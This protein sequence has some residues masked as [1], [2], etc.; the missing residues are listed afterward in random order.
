M[1]YL[2]LI[3][4]ILAIFTHSYCQTYGDSNLIALDEI[5]E[6]KEF[7]IEKKQD[8]I[9]KLKNSLYSKIDFLS[10][11]ELFDFYL[12]LTE[13]YETF[14]FDSA[15]HYAV[16]LD[17]V[18]KQINDPDKLAIAQTK[19]ANVLISAGLFSEMLDT[20]RSVD[21]RN[22]SNRTKAYYYTVLSRGYFDMESFSQNLHY[23]TLY[24]NKGMAL[25]DSAMKFYPENSWQYLSLKAQKDI[26]TGNNNE[27]IK[28]LENLIFNYDLSND[29][30]AI[31]L[32]SLAFTYDILGMNDKAL[33]YMVEASIA[34]FRAAK[35][36]TV[37]LLFVANYLLEKG[38]VE[39]A[40]RYINIA[41]ED[42]R[43][44]GSNF[45]IWQVSQFLPFIKSEH[46]VTIEKQK[47]QLWYYVIA[48]SVLSL[49]VLVFLFVIVRQVIKLRKAKRLVE[50]INRRL[51]HTNEELIVANKIKEKYV[52]YFFSVNSQLIEKLDKFKK[53]LKRKV[54]RRQ[55][56]DLALELESVNINHEKQN[57]YKSF[58]LA[59]L[60]IFPD[61]VSKFN[62]LIKEDENI[63]LKEGQLL[64]T[65]LRIFALIRLGIH[66]SDK[67]S[68]IL[69]Y[70]VNTVYAYKSKVKNKSVVQSEDFE[71]E[72]MKI[73]HY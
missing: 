57:L 45:R 47:Q 72:I 67:I 44:Y 42:S 50:D 63:I 7:F 9:N 31:Q 13:L 35:K 39:R 4:N 68:K 52:G 54:D 5:I 20:M 70:S 19:L 2:L 12:E 17:K 10:R 6:S 1:K 43:F 22:I 29:Q 24:S 37:A 38:D 69:G 48:V 66:D 14:K 40:S 65:E 15:Y 46:I 28:T 32:M 34:D 11:T 36:E 73:K 53:S 26:K 27:A 21:I 51:T 33:H 18:S 64:N 59:F 49:I 3:I 58:D 30:V 25:I 61:F 23:D 71:S 55:F 62:K 41:L 8:K 60:K 56:D 16:K